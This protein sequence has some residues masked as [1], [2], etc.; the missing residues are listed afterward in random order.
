MIKKMQQG[1]CSRLCERLGIHNPSS[2]R[3]VD[4]IALEGI[5]QPVVE[6]L[7]VHYDL[8]I[9]HRNYKSRP[10]E[11]EFK[12]I[13][14]LINNADRIVI[15]TLKVPHSLLVKRINSRLLEFLCCFFGVRRIEDH[16]PHGNQTRIGWKKIRRLWNRRKVYK[17]G[18][19]DLLYEK[20]FNYLNRCNVT[21]H[22]LLDNSQAGVI[23]V[24]PYTKEGT[25]CRGVEEIRDG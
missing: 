9:G 10:K 20:W 17:C 6:R 18:G 2:W 12:L 11:N 22:W 24:F 15:V 1:N 4:C 3:Y 23:R 19:I 25:G 16:P 14:E 13:Y 8:Q 5:H 7:V 21:S